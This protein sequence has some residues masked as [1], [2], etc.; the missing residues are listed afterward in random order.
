MED[1]NPRLGI[2]IIIFLILLNAGFTMIK[3]AFDNL[4]E[5]TVR[6]KAEEG[7]LRSAK[8]V[9]LLNKLDYYRHALLLVLVAMNTLIGVVWMQ[10]IL[11]YVNRLAHSDY[12]KNGY[13][14]MYTVLLVMVSTLIGN[15]L[16]QKYAA[17]HAHNVVY[18][19]AGVIRILGVLLRPFTWILEKSMYFIFGVMGIKASELQEN[20]TEDEIISMVNEG[21]EQGVFDADEV[22]MIANIIELDEKEAQDIMTHKKK[23]VAVNATMNIE[24]A[25]HFM[26]S[27]KYTRYPLYEENRDNI[28]GI[29]HL[30]DVIAAYIAEDHRNKS[31]KEI[32]R[33]AYY[34]PDTQ[35]INIL[36][37]EMQSKNIHMA[38][39][40]DEYGQ[41]A[42]LVAME[43]FIEEIVGNI[44][45][46]Y[47]EEEK[48]IIAKEEDYVIVKGAIYLEDL[49]EET[50]IDLVNEDFDTLNGLLIS[51]LDRIPEDGEQA[52]LNHSGYQFEIL[53]TKDKMIGRVRISKLPE[54]EEKREEVQLDHAENM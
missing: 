10:Q 41:T 37:H 33:D 12:I 27:E 11:G 49:E 2:L 19:Y 44:Q 29:L 9:I 5:S 32:A 21:H 20:I 38:I 45:D 24:E 23:I 13:I 48:L 40:I 4:S 28:I 31:L 52:L 35:N 3:T 26:L 14:I 18:R 42:G 17:K 50:G 16:P 6:K 47:D 54:E 7:D 34:V 36:F 46:E 39:V 25:L 8:L 43:D 22:E 51:L 15:I 30:K 53:E 1:G